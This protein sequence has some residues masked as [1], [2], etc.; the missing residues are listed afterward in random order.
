MAQLKVSDLSK[1]EQEK[2]LRDAADVGL[3]GVFDNW[4]VEKLKK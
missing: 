2:I 4:G 1:E 3:K